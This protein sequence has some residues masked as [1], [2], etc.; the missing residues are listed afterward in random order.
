MRHLNIVIAA[1]RKTAAHAEHTARCPH[2]LPSSPDM[3]ARAASVAWLKGSMRQT[4]PK[5]LSSGTLPR[6]NQMPPMIPHSEISMEEQGGADLSD[7]SAPKNSPA[8]MKNRAIGMS[9]AQES[10]TPPR[11]SDSPDIAPI[12]AEQA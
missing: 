7:S 6:S 10:S 9:S 2:M 5:I 11:G 12:T 4:R 1:I 8:D 3:A